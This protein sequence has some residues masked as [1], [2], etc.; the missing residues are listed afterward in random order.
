MQIRRYE[1]TPKIINPFQNDRVNRGVAVFGNRVF[2]G[3]LDAALVALD[4]RTGLP[5]WEVQLADALQGYGITAAPLV[6]KDRII[7]G[8][9]AADNAIRGLVD[10]THAA[11]A[12]PSR[13]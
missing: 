7:V 12:K 13:P 6:I 9:S 10:P 5:M 8:V 2:F 3:T 4:A 11:H 1:R